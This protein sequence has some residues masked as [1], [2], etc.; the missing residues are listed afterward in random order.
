M[1][2]GVLGH[3]PRVFWEMTPREVQWAIDGYAR[4]QGVTDDPVVDRDEYE[5][6]LQAA[7]ET[8]RALGLIH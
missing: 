4:H 7:R 8:Q 2:V 5:A 1:I 6:A 3:S